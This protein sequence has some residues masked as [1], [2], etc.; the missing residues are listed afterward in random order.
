MEHLKMTWK[1]HVLKLDTVHHII[2]S[3]SGSSTFPTPV[4]RCHCDCHQN[5][6]C[7]CHCDVIRVFTVIHGI[8]PPPPLS[9][10]PR[11]SPS[12]ESLLSSLTCKT[13]LL[14]FSLD[15]V[16]LMD[17]EK[18]SSSCFALTQ[19]LSCSECVC[20]LDAHSTAFSF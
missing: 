16:G 14:S 7:R 10:G 1:N 11:L 6:V 20:P 3:E 15:P 2:P 13:P 4:C 18:S 12:S 5:L 17:H 9:T 8:H 19:R